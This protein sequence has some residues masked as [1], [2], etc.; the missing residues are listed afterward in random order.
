MSKTDLALKM[1]DSKAV[2]RTEFSILGSLEV[3]CNGRL[4][5]LPGL[6]QQKLLAILLL[7]VNVPVPYERLV[8]LLWDVPPRSTRQQIHNAVAGLRRALLPMADVCELTTT[9]NGYQVRV[10]ADTID[11]NR[12]TTMVTEA[13]W[14]DRRAQQQEA[15]ALLQAAQRLWRGPALAGLTGRHIENVAARLNEGR[16]G[17]I[18]RMMAIH[19]Q[20]GGAGALVADLTELVAEH[21]YRESLRASLMEALRQAGRQADALA[22]YERGRQLLAEN[23]GIDP[24]P[25]LRRQYLQVLQS[26]GGIE[27]G[28]TEGEPGQGRLVDSEP[29]GLFRSG[30]YLPHDIREFVGREHEVEQLTRTALGASD[31][32]VISPID[33]MGGTGKTALAVHLAHRLRF[34]YP[35]GQYFVELHGFCSGRKPL[36]SSQ[37]LEHLLLQ[38]GT[39]VDAIPP[40]LPGRSALWRARLAGRRVLMLLDDAVD[41]AQVRPLIPGTGEIFVMV[42]SRRRLTAIEGAVPLSLDSLPHDDAL[43]LF[44]QVAGEARTYGE[45]DSIATAVEHCGLLPLAIRIAAARFRD[46]ARWTVQDLVEQLRDQRSRARFLAAGDRDVMAAL[47]LS[48]QQLTPDHQRM[49]RLLSLHPNDDLDIWSVAALTDVT[50]DESEYFLEALYDDNLLLQQAAGRYQFH[51]LVRDCS[52]ELLRDFDDEKTQLAATQRLRDFRSYYRSHGIG[53]SELSRD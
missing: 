23:F 19:L 53:R 35:D 34:D 28:A 51:D 45:R 52:R 29:A 40:D 39:P 25:M 5:R 21:P 37:A 10:A 15:L 38:T 27:S 11:A 26:E 12:F 36:T 42:T 9:E 31:F 24:G 33:G 2:H 6:R 46:R 47:A 14:L 44:V 16:L 22:V 8:D 50:V 43:K 30:N 3:W 48:Y 13:E 17:A 4:L 7:S 20:L 32:V 1:I 18:E 41:A 49:F